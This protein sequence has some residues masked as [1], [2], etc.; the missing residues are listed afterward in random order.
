MAAE[1]EEA[2]ERKRRERREKREERDSET[3]GKLNRFKEIITE[4]VLEE[5]RER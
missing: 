2:R 4:C 1:R 5:M 3:N